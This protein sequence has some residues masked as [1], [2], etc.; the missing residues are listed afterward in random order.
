[1]ITYVNAS[2]LDANEQI[3]VHGCNAQ[4][5]MRSGV[6]KAIR[7]KWPEASYDPYIKEYE[8]NGLRVG[9]T[10]LGVTSCG[11]IIANAITQEFYG[12][13]GK[14]YLSYDALI[15]VF[16][17]IDNNILSAHDD[18]YETIAM[19]KIGSGLAGG[20]WEI[21]EEIISTCFVNRNVVIYVY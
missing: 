6:A 21:I 18:G 10:I 16:S 2:I 5:K 7:E 1:M 19:P 15:E 4:G 12:Y 8:N 14:L 3:I 9:S 13:D 17:Y 11:K 20:N